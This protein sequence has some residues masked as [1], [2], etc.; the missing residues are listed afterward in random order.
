MT[1]STADP[2]HVT[3]MAAGELRAALAALEQ[4][5]HVT[6]ASSLMAIDAISWHAIE[7]RLVTVGGSLSELLAAIGRKP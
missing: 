7:R 5:D 2:E 4:G 3:L 1:H 6:A